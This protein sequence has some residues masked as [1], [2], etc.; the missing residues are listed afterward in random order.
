MNTKLKLVF[1]S[2]TETFV[3]FNKRRNWR[4]EIT[5]TYGSY[6]DDNNCNTSDNRNK[7]NNDSN[8]DE[9]KDD[10]RKRNRETR[11]LF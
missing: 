4:S 2:S 3:A 10:R 7:N 9:N 8:D 11:C 5:M 1:E 6:N